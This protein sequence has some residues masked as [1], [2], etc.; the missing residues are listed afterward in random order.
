MDIYQYLELLDCNMSNCG[1]RRANG[2]AKL[3]AGVL[4]GV[5]MVLLLCRYEYLK[6]T[7]SF[8]I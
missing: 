6:M 1:M 3:E 5:C 7:V 4:C 8:S 2:C